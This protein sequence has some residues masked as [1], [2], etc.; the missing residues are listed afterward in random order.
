MKYFKVFIF[1]VVAGFFNFSVSADR[2]SE[3]LLK[4]YL[5]EAAGYCERLQK[6]SF[7]FICTEKILIK[8]EELILE[9]LQPERRKIKRKKYRINYVFDY[10]IISKKG[11]V[12]ERRIKRTGS[13]GT[14]EIDPSKLVLFFLMEKSVY[15]PNS[16]LDKEKQVLYV[17]ELIGKEEIKNRQHIVLKAVPKKPGEIFFS[18]ATIYLDAENYSIRKLSVVPTFMKGYSIMKRAAKKFKSKLLLKCEMHFNHE[19]NGLYFPTRIVVTE[20][21]KGGAFIF[22]NMGP[23]GW[24]KNQTVFKYYNYQFFKID[25]E[26]KIRD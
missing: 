25:T 1:I 15:G 12:S 17:F 23:A 14:K 2:S 7:H 21:Y 24:E 16:I 20:R 18:S 6:E 11:K 13:K 3:D 4:N 22:R 19:Y 9:S 8:N 26:V 5:N 10:Q